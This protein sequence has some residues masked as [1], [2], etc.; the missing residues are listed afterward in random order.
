MDIRRRFTYDYNRG[1][2]NNTSIPDNEIWY[3]TSD[4]NII[5]TDPDMWFE[6]GYISNVYIDGVGRLTCKYPIEWINEGAFADC[7]SL[8]SIIFPN[9]LRSIGDW[10]FYGCSSLTSITIPESVTEF[11]FNTFGNCNSLELFTSQFAS[12]D[13][14]CLIKDGEL[15]A[16]APAELA[17]YVIPN[18]V[19]KIFDGAFKGCSSI[20]SIIIS[21]SVTEIGYSVFT[22]CSSLTS[23][24]I[25][26]RVTSIGY[27]AF[28][29]CSSLKEVYCKAIRPPSVNYLYFDTTEND[30][31]IYVPKAAVYSYKNAW[32]WCEYESN[33]VGYS[34]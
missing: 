34:F 28:D 2:N 25:G 31:K 10:A 26:N 24:T 17:E 6:F 27:S 3:T 13:G 30:F 23:I 19:T 29:G 4:G 21:D 12:E 9:S 8:T 5:I 32:S 18:N 7:S 14:R 22:D 16:F 15:I 1:I 33:I 11:G 20:T